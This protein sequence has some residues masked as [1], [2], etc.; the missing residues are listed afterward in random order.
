MTT[1]Q[2]LLL[3]LIPAMS[4]LDRQRGTPKDDEIIPKLPALLGIGY[5]CAVF[6]GHWLDW[7]AAVITAAVAVIHNFSFGEPL[8]HAL[9]GRGGVVAADGT[10]YE[11]WQVGSLLQSNPWVAL[12][13]R[14][15]MLG[16]A[17]VAALDWQAAAQIAVA[18]A[19]A[20]PLAPAV[21]RYILKMPTRTKEQA[22]RAWAANEWTRGAA[23][24]VLL[25]IAG[26]V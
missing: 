13:V 11:K 8:G 15:A 5:L 21:V 16:L 20:F 1:Q 25:W 7:Q 4:W 10:V 9:T 24:G 6:T 26:L 3:L 22:G 17:G 2:L 12:A 23:A 14:G 19:I 18:W